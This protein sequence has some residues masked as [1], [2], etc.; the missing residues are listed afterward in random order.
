MVRSLSVLPSHFTHIVYNVLR[1]NFKG[2]IVVDFGCGFG[3]WGHL[4]RTFVEIG[5]NEAQMIGFDVF[6]PYLKN[7]KK[8]NP[9]DELILC[10]ARHLPFRKKAVDISLAFEILE[11]MEK[12]E[13]PRFLQSLEEVSKE[14]IVMTFPS[15]RYKQD[16]V[17]GNVFQKHRSAW[18]AKEI[19]KHG[20]S[21]Y[22][23]GTEFAL[24][25]LLSRLPW[26]FIQRLTKRRLLEI[27]VIAFKRSP[28][29]TK[30]K[31]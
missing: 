11:H 1:L 7:L 26:H 10:D 23:V 15:G 17:D 29:P 24:G 4:V 19:R 18:S 27:L 25:R 28:K 16:E 20:F 8:Y 22:L 31:N 13:G 5:G 12:R 21:A 2:K 3:R 9:Y 30:N 14:A 6:S